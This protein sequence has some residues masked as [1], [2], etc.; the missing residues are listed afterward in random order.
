MKSIIFCLLLFTFQARAQL[1]AC[2]ETRYDFKAGCNK[3]SVQFDVSA[4]EGGDGGFQPA[5]SVSC[6][7][8]EAVATY[9][10]ANKSYRAV[11]SFT[12]GDW[13]QKGKVWSFQ[14]KSS[15]VVSEDISIRLKSNSNKK[16]ELPLPVPATEIDSALNQTPPAANENEK[17]ET[18]VALAVPLLAPS[19]PSAESSQAEQSLKAPE[20]K[21]DEKTDTKDE[22][23]PDA[24]ADKKPDLIAV[25]K[26]AEKASDKPAEQAAVKD[27]DFKLLGWMS[28]EHENF[29]NFGDQI[30]SAANAFNSADPNNQNSNMNAIAVFGFSA[31][32]SSHQFVSLF[33]VGEVYFGETTSGGSQGLRSKNIEVRNLYVEEK[34]NDKWSVLLGLRSVAS[35]PRGFILK[36]EYA[37]WSLSRKHENLTSSF[38]QAEAVNSKPG[39]TAIRDQYLGFS[40]GIQMSEKSVFNLF[41]VYRNTRETFADSIDLIT[42][43][44][45]K[46]EYNWLGVQGSHRF[47]SGFGLEGSAILSNAKY[48][49]ENAAEGA[50]A[51]DSTNSWLAHLQL[52]K[53][54]G[55]G[56]S[57][58]AQQLMTP[59][60]NDSRTATDRRILGRR[61]NFASPSPSSAYLLTVATSDGRDEAAGSLRAGDRIIGRLDID[62]G[63]Q[64]SILSLKK[65]FLDKF[66]ALIRY[67]MLK[68]AVVRTSTSSADYGTESDVVL[69]Y[70]FDQQAQFISEYGVFK[71]GA[72]FTNRE[73]ASLLSFRY[74]LNF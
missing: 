70:N 62:E 7:K 51:T 15:E 40:H 58:G 44:S 23:K 21:L 74:K 12:N 69:T 28:V 73:E 57:I 66:E 11:F 1:Q 24:K 68:T 22:A 49:G 50:G 35:D 33:E 45:G 18:T 48:K 2:G 63:L 72:F 39:T 14:K 52:D 5:T 61:K 37:G 19:A 32:K 8:D 46:S 20:T 59:G 13:K 65:S 34:L 25:E 64:V 56:W 3:N 30:S 27:W 71:P 43:Y 9:K 53:E 26:P 31:E 67:G 54:F 6:K 38:W 29:K 60:S 16:S 41:G 4:C 17:N 42:E 10:T 55:S 47:D 36:D